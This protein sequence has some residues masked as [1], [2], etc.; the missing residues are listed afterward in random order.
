[1]TLEPKRGTIF[2][3]HGETLSRPP[4]SLADLNLPPGVQALAETR[5]NAAIE[6]LREDNRDELKKLIEKHTRRWQVAAALL[7]VLNLASWFIAPQQIKKWAKDYVQ[8]RMTA[9]ELK[10]AADVA[11]SAQMG[12]YVRSQLDPLRRDISQKQAQLASAQNAITR[13]VR[14]QQLAIAAKAGGLADYEEL[15]QTAEAKSGDTS[16]AKAALKEVELYYDADRGQLIYQTL[17][18]A[19]SRQNP[20]WSYEEMLL[21][22]AANDPTYREAAA[23]TISQI[24]ESDKSKGIVEDMMNALKAESNLRVIA[25]LSRAISLFTKVE[26]KPLDRQAIIS[27][28]KLHDKDPV[29][30]SPY[31]GFRKAAALFDAPESTGK[32]QNIIGFLDDTLQVDPAAIYSRSLKLR[33]LIALGNLSEADSEAAQ[34]EKQQGD[35]RWALLWKALL[36]FEESKPDEAVTAINGAFSRSPEMAQIAKNDPAFASFL[37]NPK[38]VWPKS[39]P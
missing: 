8:Q 2:G 13:Q 29:Y 18:D 37:E 26:F 22:L 16:A 32:A 38:I 6:Q 11:I 27:W 24:G 3:E 4:D 14:I 17:V 34:I 21:R 5:I 9:P 39:E 31:G 7:F 20:G 23:N 35:F 15:K 28:W 19:V 36:L 33:L 25:R 12:D 10:R 30:R 1:M